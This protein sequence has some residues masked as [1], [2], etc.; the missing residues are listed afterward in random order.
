MDSCLRKDSGPG[1]L[2]ALRVGLLRVPLIA[3][4]VNR[5]TYRPQQ[6][7][8]L[9]CSRGTRR[10]LDPAE[11]RARPRR[12]ISD[13][14]TSDAQDVEVRAGCAWISGIQDFPFSGFRAFGNTAD[15]CSVPAFV[16]TRFPGFQLTGFMGFPI[17]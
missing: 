9:P 5:G 7:P 16:K 13:Q 17:S 15:T 3:R 11:Y 2:G 8:P 6:T 12:E 4:L 1:H 14:V 10:S